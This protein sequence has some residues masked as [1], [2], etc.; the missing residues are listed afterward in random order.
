MEILTRIFSFVFETYT[1]RL[2]IMRYGFERW[3]ATRFPRSSHFIISK[4]IHLAAQQARLDCFSS[5][6]EH[7]VPWKDPRR[8]DPPYLRL[9]SRVNEYLGKRI[10][11][12]VYL[13]EPLGGSRWI[14]SLIQGVDTRYPVAL[15]FRVKT[16]TDSSFWKCVAKVPITT[17]SSGDIDKELET[18]LNIDIP[19]QVRGHKHHNMRGFV[20]YSWSQAPKNAEIYL[21]AHRTCSLPWLSLRIPLLSC[22]ILLL[23]RAKAD[24]CFSGHRFRLERRLAQA[25]DKIYSRN[26]YPVLGH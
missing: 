21:A 24:S 15:E 25:R 16:I 3:K 17:I 19:E 9:Q 5:V 7:N 20:E 18:W 2:C 10:Q 4:K 26:S 6:V 23:D 1:P 13:M 8:L 14:P 11:R 22:P 12:H